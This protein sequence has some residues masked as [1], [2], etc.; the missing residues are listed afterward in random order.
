[1][2]NRKKVKTNELLLLTSQ[3]MWPATR[4]NLKLVQAQLPSEEPEE[5]EPTEDTPTDTEEEEELEEESQEDEEEP[6]AEETTAQG[7]PFFMIAYTGGALRLL[8]FGDPIVVDLAGLDLGRQ[9]R[10]VLLNHEM[11]LDAI[12]GQTSRIAVEGGQLVVEGVLFDSTEVGERV[13][14]LADAG[15]AWQASIGATALETEYIP[16]GTQIEVNGK[17]FVGPLNL[18][19]RAKLGEVSFVAVGA[20]DETSVQMKSQLSLTSKFQE[21]SAM[22]YFRSYRS[23][24]GRLAKLKSIRASRPHGPYLATGKVN[25]KFTQAQLLEAALA[26]TRP[27]QHEKYYSPELLQAAEDLYGRRLKLRQALFI[28]AQA[29]GYTGSPYVDSS[30]LREVLH[31]AW[32]PS[33]GIRAA[34][35]TSTLSLPNIL[36]NVLNKELRE[37]FQE[38]DQTWREIAIV[39]SVSDF[40]TVTSI[41]LLD[42]MEYEEVAPDGELKHGTVSEETYTRQARTYGKIFTLTRDKIIN[43]DLGAFDDIRVRLGAG[44]ARKLNTVFWSTFL[45]NSTFFT[46]ARGNYITGATTALDEAG[47]GLQAGI[48]AFRKLKSPDGKRIG[49]MPTILLVPPELQFVAQRLYQSTT[50]DP[51]N[52]GAMG[53]A[54]IHAGRYRPVVSD[55]LSDPAFAGSSAKAWYLFRDPTILAPVVVSFL[56]GVDT[57]TVE[58]AE[59]DFNKLGIQFRG[60]FDFGVDLAEYLAG[61][62]SKG[63]A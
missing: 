61:I 11:H 14:E 33:L 44:A 55:W 25:P 58:A 26:L 43:D 32:N 17:T 16:E 54:N 41:R 23:P 62:K 47:T 37:G 35:G 50:V 29:N 3:V 53:T 15:F 60:Y 40:K 57:P 51:G 52:G 49:G 27:L 8:G 2:T 13:A 4:S 28:A 20:D 19:R 56:D 63:E 39:R 36:S 18:V 22:S 6:E 46:T 24:S 5:E 30:N 59:A 12:L 31:Y 42:N 9:V 1:M 38:Q 48:V 34:H 10:P 21:A 45:N 7:R